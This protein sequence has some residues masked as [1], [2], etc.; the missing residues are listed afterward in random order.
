MFDRLLR[1]P[2]LVLLVF[3]ILCFAAVGTATLLG[4]AFHLEVCSMCWF[5]RLS[6]L[7][8]GCGFLLAAAWPRGQI[9]TRRIAELGMLLG[10]ASAARQTYLMTH[11]DQASGS[12]G[13]GLFYYLKM[14]N[15][16]AFFRA[17]MAGGLDCAE[18]QQAI[19][20]LALP[21]WSLIAFIVLIA[22]YLLWSFSKKR[23][24]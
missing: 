9:A 20:G 14:G 6:F 21:E 3:G 23:K 18:N 5:Q 12:C 8:A 16:E 15:Y 10:V 17:G 22:V 11:L 19:L 4:I 1:T 13:A 24:A 7:L 2:R